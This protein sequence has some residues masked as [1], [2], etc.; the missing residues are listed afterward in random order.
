MARAQAGAPPFA[1][2]GEERLEHALDQVG[3]DAHAVVGHADHHVRAGRDVPHA[4]GSAHHETIDGH[5]EAPA[6][7]HRVAGV[8][9]EVDEDLLQTRRI[10]LHEPR[11]TGRLGHQL[12]VLAQN[13]PQHLAEVAQ[14]GVGIHGPR[15]GDLVTGESEQ[16]AGEPRGALGRG[17]HLHEIALL[18]R[19]AG[20]QRLEGERAVADDDR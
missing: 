3:L 20:P 12:D 18:H 16:L 13:A 5:D 15:R 14:H 6:L 9:G 2:G 1:L 19:L 8:D 7:G 10:H 4:V 17:D 11:V